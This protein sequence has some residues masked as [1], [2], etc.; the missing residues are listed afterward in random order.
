[1]LIDIPEAYDPEAV[2]ELTAV[3]V[4]DV[5]STITVPKSP[6]AASAVLPAASLIV[7]E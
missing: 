6:L 5:A 2:V 1:M 7:P 3:T 4:A